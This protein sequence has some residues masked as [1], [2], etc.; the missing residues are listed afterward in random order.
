MLMHFG[1]IDTTSSTDP[2]LTPAALAS[3]RL[4][5]TP[6]AT[7]LRAASVV[8]GQRITARAHELAAQDPSKSWLSELSE[9]ALDGYLWSVGKKGELRDIERV[10]E[11]R[12]YMY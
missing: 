1:V 8:A 2:S 5:S 11:R 10:A 9:H 7:R 6:S 12:T 3:N 4:I